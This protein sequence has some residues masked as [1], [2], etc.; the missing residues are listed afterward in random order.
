MSD[1]KGKCLLVTET[2]IH[3]LLMVLP[4]KEDAFISCHFTDVRQPRK[5]KSLSP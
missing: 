5:E 4:N 1:M 3:N 2:L